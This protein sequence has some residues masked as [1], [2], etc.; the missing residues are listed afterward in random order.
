LQRLR[1]VFGAKGKPLALPIELQARYWGIATL[2]FLLVLWGLGDV[3]LPFILGGAIA[4][5]L[6]PI[7]DWFE[8]RGLSRGFAVAVITLIGLVIFIALVM[9]ILP[10]LIEQGRELVRTLPAA[11]GRLRDYLIERFPEMMVEDSAVNQQFLSLASILEEKGGQLISS[12]FSSFNSLFNILL[13]ALI[14][15]VVSIYLLVD[16][17]RLVARIDQLLPRDHAPTLRRLATQMDQTLAGFIRG[18]GTVCLVLGIFYAAALMIAGLNFGL[19]IGAIAGLVTFIPYVGAIVGGGLSIGLAIFQTWSESAADVAAGVEGAT[20]GVDWIYVLI[21]YLIFQFGQ[22]VEGNILTP[23]LVGS[24]VGLHPVWLLMALSV[25]GSLF[26]FTGLLVAV[27]LAALIGVLVRFASEQYT[28]SR[29][30][31]GLEATL[32]PPDLDEPS[33]AE[34]ADILAG[35]D[36]ADPPRDA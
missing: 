3:L 17:D 33:D 25:F 9:L 5:C 34:T 23:N 10:T 20:R 27:P 12:V 16:W 24:S 11:V 1:C 28:N 19:I 2:V 8:A 4:Y 15:P 26:G 18:Q 32:P 31:R 6:D 7:A 22:F 36:P 30:Y 14:T 29:L 13:I 21:I 35:N